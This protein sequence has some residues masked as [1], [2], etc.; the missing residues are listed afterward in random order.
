MFYGIV[1]PYIPLYVPIILYVL[2]LLFSCIEIFT[3]GFGLFGIGGIGCFLAGIIL[4]IISG[5]TA[6][7]I[8]L[9]IIGIAAV[10]IVLFAITAKS[11][12]S[13]RLSKTPLILTQNAVSSGKTQGTADYSFL[14]GK[15]G[16]TTT[17]LRPIGKAEIDG[18]NY[19][20]IA[21]DGE[22]IEG[23]EK[24]AVISA[25]GQKVIVKKV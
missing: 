16:M 24:I 6:L 23:G 4:R 18:T 1:L 7:E 9:T 8:I 12:Q 22:V 25:E 3:P 17:F 20:V 10:V 21:A 5:G 13:G 14:V 2:G 19:D 11:A 15:E